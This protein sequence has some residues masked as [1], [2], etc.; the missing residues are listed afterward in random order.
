MTV[1][2]PRRAG[3]SPPYAARI[4]A[5]LVFVPVRDKLGAMNRPRTA[6]LPR[7][8]WI[9]LVL[10]CLVLGS[11]SCAKLSF[12]RRSQTSGTFTSTGFSLTILSVDLPKQ[13]LD[14]ARENASDSELSNLEIQD[15]VVFP[16]LGPLDFLLDIIGVR[17]AR[18]R[19]TWGFGGS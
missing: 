19:G 8:P 3:P 10:A 2:S 17:W 9:V 13:A 14:I 6:P 7:Q 1:P 4:A 15:A 12:Q 5:P 11:S 18:V 16:Y